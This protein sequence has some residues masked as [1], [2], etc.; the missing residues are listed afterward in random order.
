MFYLKNIQFTIFRFLSNAQEV[1]ST[2]QIKNVA[3]DDNSGQSARN[4]V[5]LDAPWVGVVSP[6]ALLLAAKMHCSTSRL[7]VFSFNSFCFSNLRT[8]IFLVSLLIPIEYSV[9][10]HKPY[11]VAR[12]RALLFLDFLL[13]SPCLIHINFCPMFFCHQSFFWLDPRSIADR[14]ASRLDR[15]SCHDKKRHHTEPHRT[16]TEHRT[17]QSTDIPHI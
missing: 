15:V 13:M 11:F 6:I 3:W 9:D 7:I 8:L 14:R 10:C 4:V 2:F 12:K 5:M 1:L 16:Y 17:T